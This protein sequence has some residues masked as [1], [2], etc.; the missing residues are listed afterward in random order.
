MGLPQRSADAGS[1]VFVRCIITA[2][3]LAVPDQYYLH[4]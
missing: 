3:F 1:Q 2:R 4:C